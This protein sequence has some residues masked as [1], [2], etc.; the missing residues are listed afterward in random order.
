MIIL[1]SKITDITKLFF[2]SI[3]LLLLQSCS[4]TQD[5]EQVLIDDEKP[6][7]ETNEEEAYIKYTENILKNSKSSNIIVLLGV[8]GDSGIRMM[9]VCPDQGDKKIRWCWNE[10]FPVVKNSIAMMSLDL[11]E[12]AEILAQV[13]HVSRTKYQPYLPLGNKSKLITMKS[14]NMYYFGMIDSDAATDVMVEEENKELLDQF[15]DKYSKYLKPYK[16][17]SQ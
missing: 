8:I 4:T 5:Q 2:F 16:L 3:I 11:G 6:S 9:R 7:V 15:L 17:S 14:G 1:K 12:D 13:T 10:R